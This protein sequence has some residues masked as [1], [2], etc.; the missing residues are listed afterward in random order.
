MVAY[1]P[2]NEKGFRLERLIIGYPVRIAQRQAL[3]RLIVG[4]TGR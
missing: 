3:H 1:E 4:R 2:S